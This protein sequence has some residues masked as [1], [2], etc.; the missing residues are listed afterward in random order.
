MGPAEHKE[1][2]VSSLLFMMEYNGLPRGQ[3]QIHRI[4]H[5][6]HPFHGTKPRSL[7]LNGI[8]LKILSSLHQ[9]QMIKLPCGIWLLSKMTKI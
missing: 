9:E 6:S 5:P 3:V 2:G 8:L 1:N 7:Q 4:L